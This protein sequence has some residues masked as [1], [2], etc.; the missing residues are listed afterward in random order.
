MFDN[1]T[2]VYSTSRMYEAELVKGML[3][4]NGIEC[5]SMNKQDSVYLFGEIEIMVPTDQSFMAKQL[6]LT[7][8]NE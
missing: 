7:F 4:E 5:V 2:T 3:G 6:I 1:W 8:Q